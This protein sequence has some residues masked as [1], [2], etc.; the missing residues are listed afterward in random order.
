MP[1]TYAVNK[2]KDRSKHRTLDRVLNHY[3]EVPM[4]E[5]FRLGQK[6]IRIVTD[7]L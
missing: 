3:E 4:I 1:K 5:V 7:H 2:K 6:L